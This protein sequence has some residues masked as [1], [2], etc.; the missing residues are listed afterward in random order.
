MRSQDILTNCKPSLLVI[1]NEWVLIFELNYKIDIIK[2]DLRFETQIFCLR[3]VGR[4][5]GRTPSIQRFNR[6]CSFA[7]W[8]LFVRPIVRVKWD[9]YNW[10][11]CLASSAQPCADVVL[12]IIVRR[13]VIPGQISG[14]VGWEESYLLGH[15]EGWETHWMLYRVLCEGGLSWAEDK[16]R[17]SQI[18]F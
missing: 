5:D 10:E 12:I 8:R 17:T 14:P 9:D 3:V 16:H 18:D 2:M 1:L 11:I 13:H 6:S 7:V 15:V 4:T